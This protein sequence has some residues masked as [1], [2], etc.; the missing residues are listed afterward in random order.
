MKVVRNA[1]NGGR[2]LWRS[3]W[4][5]IGAAVAV[6]LGGGGLFAVQAASSPASSVVTITPVRA[7]DTRSDVGLD[8]P[9]VS[10]VSQKLKVP[11]GAV[12]A[13][14]TGV[15]LNVTVVAPTAAGFVTIR[16]GDATGTPSTSSLNFD[17]GADV[18]NSVQV[19]LPITGPNAGE[20]D[21]TYDAYGAAG[22]ST[23]MVIDIVGYM[24][25]G[26]GGATG[27]AGPTGATGAAGPAG[28]TGATGA[29]GPQG[30]GF[31]NGTG[32]TDIGPSGNQLTV[33]GF[34]DAGGCAFYVY[35]GTSGT[36]TGWLTTNGVASDF[37]LGQFATFQPNSASPTAYSLRVETSFGLVTLNY[38]LSLSG[39]QTCRNSWQY[40]VATN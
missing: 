4:A 14:A 13:G 24:I 15:L 37:S 35:N 34:W 18:A 9:L 16:P 39:A 12:P 20:I 3:R 30:P 19:G 27:P 29:A 2:G 7:I 8:G 25:P 17:T 38:W 40:V 10:A 31:S 23:D 21:I 26:G 32:P 33:L 6:T 11:G 36:V 1:A 22:P 5:A 28:P